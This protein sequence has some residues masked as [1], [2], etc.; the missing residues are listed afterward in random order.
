MT[1]PVYLFVYDLS[2]GLARV[3]SPHLLG[4]TL[5]G[6]FHTSVVVG[7]KEVF[8]GQGVSVTAPGGS[9]FG[10]PLRRL[11]LGTT[12]LSSES[13]DELLLSLSQE[14]RAERYHLLHNNC[15]HFSD[16]LAQLLVGQPIPSEYVRQAELVREIPA[17]AALLS[18][19]AAVGVPIT[20]ADGVA[21]QSVAVPVASA[22]P[23][24]DEEVFA[25]LVRQHHA[26]YMAA[27]CSN[28]EATERAVE[29][30]LS[31]MPPSTH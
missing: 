29:A 18:P 17:L 24:D 7:G 27:G 15:N 14:W 12:Q 21:V 20:P 4:R 28:E 25:A 26:A 3:L 1:T 9:H 30:A 6:I 8:F 16:A 31:G 11:Q 10:Q 22:T 2:G 13:I 5:E 23:L 19:A